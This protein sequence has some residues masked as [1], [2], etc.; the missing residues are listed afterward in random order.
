MDVVDRVVQWF[1]D[2]LYAR[3]P[4][5]EPF[6]TSDFWP[7]SGMALLEQLD[8]VPMGSILAYARQDAVFNRFLNHE[9]ASAFWQKRA[10]L[11]HPNTYSSFILNGRVLPANY[12]EPFP[13]GYSTWRQHYMATR[14]MGAQIAKISQIEVLDVSAE[15][16]SVKHVKEKVQVNSRWLLDRDNGVLE[17]NDNQEYV[18]YDFGNKIKERFGRNS[19]LLLDYVVFVSSPT[20]LVF[21]IVTGTYKEHEI[22]FQ[23]SKPIPRSGNEFIVEGQRFSIRGSGE[24]MVV[25]IVA[26]N[27]SYW[28]GWDYAKF[29][30]RHSYNYAYWRD[31]QVNQPGA[32]YVFNSQVGPAGVVNFARR[33]YFIGFPRVKGGLLSKESFFL[34]EKPRVDNIEV[35]NILKIEDNEEVQAK[36]TPI[37]NFTLAAYLNGGSGGGLYLAPTCIFGDV[38]GWET[39]SNNFATD[40]TGNIDPVWSSPILLFLS[41]K[42]HFLTIQ[43]SHEEIGKLFPKLHANLSVLIEVLAINPKYILLKT[44]LQLQSFPLQDSIIEVSL[45]DLLKPYLPSIASPLPCNYCEQMAAGVCKGCSQ[46]YCSR[47]CQE[48]DW[49][50]HREICSRTEK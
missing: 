22:E 46:P 8:D 49:T 36:Q 47:Y 33:R 38:I 42:T 5:G 40:K 48:H 21:E 31:G 14:R 4:K 26:N 9:N 37:D 25:D 23:S 6:D 30:S 1:K 34:R 39:S 16:M 13:A 27:R 12:K 19:A 24:N 35:H 7:E 10:R 28:S 50:A 2:Q 43:I 18:R 45:V 44:N 11:D 3:E 32:E 15:Q 41:T 20:L 29:S 17:S